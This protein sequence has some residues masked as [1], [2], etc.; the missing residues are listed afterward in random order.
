M[1]KSRIRRAASI[2]LLVIFLSTHLLIQ[3]RQGGTPSQAAGAG[4]V[5]SIS[6][7]HFD[8]FY[9]PLLIKSLI[10]KD[11]TQW[12]S[13]FAKSQVKGYGLNGKDTNYRLL[14]SALENIYER[15][16]QPDFI[17]ISGDFL[18]HNFQ[19]NYV[20]ASGN[21]DPK[22]AN[23][24]ITK[25]IAFVTWMIEKRFPQTP[26]YPALGN[27]D[28][29]CGD[30]QIQ[31]GGPF[32]SATAESWKALL[33]NPANVVSFMRT[34][35]AMG[36]YSIIAPNNK[37]HRLLVL[38]TTF[39]SI[40]YENKCGDQKAQPGKDEMKWLETELQK[41]AAGK[42]RVWLLYHIPPGIDVYDTLDN[43]SQGKGSQPETFWQ[44]A[45]N[46]QFINLLAR[47][48][49]VIVGSFAGH[50]HMDSFELIRSGNNSPDSFVH[51]TP[52]ISPRFGNNPAFE[53][54]TYDR[55]SSGL[56]DYTAYYFD[57]ASAAAKKNAPV[58]WGKEY[59]FSEAYGQAMLTARSL[60]AVYVG[61]PKNVH[62][63]LTKFER[64][65]NVSNV[66]NTASPALNAQNWLAYWCGMAYLT[67]S[68]YQKC[69]SMPPA[70]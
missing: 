31:P 18:D 1:K 69:V 43:A 11:Y 39:F 40:N 59:M 12:Q 22:A 51:I 33:K 45:Y 25:T 42:E 21:K 62:G 67:P 57:R 55:S 9:D 8:P 6:D 3:A 63:H 44:P 52:A 70:K 17:I 32:L 38:N 46:Q 30:Y 24:F 28:S 36:S 66:G 60:Q 19:T 14:N 54:F 15:V 29:Y 4:K 68:D 7:I 26:V 65:Y 47:Y 13:I 16:P 5:V 20:T 50:I 53:I 58:N 37:D 61:M 27:N 48:A 49:T 34:F 56:K 2:L 64:Y 23:A 41:A 10:K 35:P